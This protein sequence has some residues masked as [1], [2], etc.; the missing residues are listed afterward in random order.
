MQHNVHIKT[1]TGSWVKVADVTG[2]QYANKSLVAGT[3]Y[4]YTIRCVNAAGTS[5]TSNY[6]SA[7]SSITY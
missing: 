1:G 6:L 2:T 3:K 4:T 7:G 5:Y